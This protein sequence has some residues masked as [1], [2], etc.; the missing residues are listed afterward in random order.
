MGKIE[1]RGRKRK[2]KRDLRKLVLASVAIAGGLGIVVVAPNVLGA[3]SKL[4]LLPDRSV[5]GAINRSRQMLVKNGFLLY[6]NNLLHLTPKGEKE[7][8][9]LEIAEFGLQKPPRWDGR[10]RILT[11]DIPERRRT[12]RTRVRQILEKIGFKRLQDS[13]WLY[14]YDCEDVIV[15]LKADLKIGKDML[16]VIV[17]ELEYDKAYRKHFNV[18]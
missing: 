7:L 12:V 1:E 6:K 8:R 11:F 17:D 15:L 18:A 2:K 10:W 5:L 16:Y 3:M 9:F 4:G 14:P 13:V